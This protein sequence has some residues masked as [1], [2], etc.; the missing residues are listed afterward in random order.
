M[1]KLLL[2]G[3]FKPFGVDDAYGEA[4][5]TM[6]LLNNQVTREQGIH[7]PRSNNPS[8]GLYIMAENVGVP[9]TVLDFPSWE[10]FTAE[11]DNGGHT[12]VGISFIAPN[13]LK[14]KR[15]AAYIRQKTPA[16]AIILG[17]HGTAI[18]GIREMVDCDEVCRG[19]G[20]AWLRRYF[21]E[22]ADKAIIHPVVPSAVTKRIYGVPMIRDAGII[23]TGVGCQN[24]CRFC[25]TSHKF[26][27]Q[28]TPFLPSGLD[29]Y[30]ACE[31]TEAAMDVRDFALMDEN[32]CKSPRRARQLLEEMEKNGKAY[33]F[34]T[35]SSAETIGKLG[36]DFLVRVG[37][38]FLWIGVESKANIFD[39]TKG[40]DLHRLIADLQ[41]HGITVLASAIL[42]LE[43]HDKNTIHEDIDWAIGLESDLL[44]FMEFGPIPGTKLYKDY[45]AEGI[46]IKDVPWP[47]QHGQ[48]EIWFNHPHFTPKETA[49]YLRDAF[50][51]KYQ[52]HGPGVINMALTYIKGYRTVL[53][54]TL[55]REA[56]G[57][58]WDA[59]SLRYVEGGAPGA[60]DEFMRQR[61]E[62]MKESALEF[63]PILRAA[64]DH[65]PNRASAE[66][67]RMA[68]ELMDETFGSPGLKDR[69]MSAAVRMAAVVERI[70]SRNGV[71]MRQPATNKVNYPD[72]RGAGR[73]G[74]AGRWVY[75]AE[76]E[77]AEE[78]TAGV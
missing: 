9:T 3:V 65:A 13:V 73:D 24:S 6:E 77:H 18:P 55:K 7:S 74:N 48:D 46:L 49:V 10:D 71:V 68:R 26:E 66:K 67:A 69:L 25:A 64:R 20:V 14:A 59:K 44:Q 12:H 50:I 57:M 63:R 27:R 76:V 70:R 33:T 43:H 23:I 16:T 54:E 11:I 29:V 47:K 37:V 35:F 72:R 34:A 1:K 36:I 22:P 5:C 8:F 2:T 39:K 40:V 78:E 17:G 53:R 30:N 21:G 45:D 15:M 60:P 51:K 75:S 61:L 56:A 4:L 62:A 38:K 28:Y 31:K 32:F 19:E 58:V 52:T 42:F 41:N